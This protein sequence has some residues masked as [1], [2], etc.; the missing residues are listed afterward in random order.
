MMGAFL[1]TFRKTTPSGPGPCMSYRVRTRTKPSAGTKPR[2][3]LLTFVQKPNLG[4][5]LASSSMHTM[6]IYQCRNVFN[7]VHS[8][9]LMR[10]RS[11][12][13]HRFCQPTPQIKLKVLKLLERHTFQSIRQSRHAKYWHRLATQHDRYKSHNQPEP[14]ALFIN[15]HASSMRL[16]QIQVSFTKLEVLYDHCTST[17]F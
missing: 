11:T 13:T 15:M 17:A 14:N 5:D 16:S 7:N 4:H 12:E 6:L 8:L 3:S 9:I 2:R 1:H 10:S